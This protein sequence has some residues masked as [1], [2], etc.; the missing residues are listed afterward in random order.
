MCESFDNSMN[1]LP[2][3]GRETLSTEN[4]FEVKDEDSSLKNSSSRLSIF[5][6]GLVFVVVTFGVITMYIYSK[7]SNEID[8]IKV[9]DY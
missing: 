4:L 8:L 7:Q 5:L 3:I 6:F 1:T 9:F 2:I